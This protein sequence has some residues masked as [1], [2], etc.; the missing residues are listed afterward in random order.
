MISSAVFAYANVWMQKKGYVQHAR[1]PPLGRPN[2]WM[3]R[4]NWGTD[5]KQQDK[6]LNKLL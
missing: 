3:S 5:P 2:F 4:D 1:R 6:Q